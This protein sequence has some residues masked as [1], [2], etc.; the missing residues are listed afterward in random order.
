VVEARASGTL[1]AVALLDLDHFK[2]INDTLG[3]GAG[4]ALLKSASARIEHAVK[5]SDVVGRLGGDEFV[6]LVRSVG[7]ASDAV[8]CVERVLA[9][10]RDPF[11]VE[12]NTLYATASAG[13]SVMSDDASAIEGGAPLLLREADIALYEAKAAGR[14]CWAIFSEGLRAEVTARVAIG[15][16]LRTALARDELMMWYQPDVDLTT[17]KVRAVEALVRWNHPDGHVRGAGTFI[18]VAE[19]SGLILEIGEWVIRQSFLE[20]ATIVAM[21]PDDPVT[22]RVNLAAAQFSGDL[23]HQIDAALAASGVPPELICL[24]IT[25]SALVRDLAFVRETLETLRTRGLRF[26][27][28]DFGAGYAS[29]T[30]LRDF[31]VELIKID[32]SF[33]MATE[34]DDRTWRLVRAI[35]T[36]ADQL[37]IAVTAEGVETREQA[38][39]LRRIGCP[40]AQGYLFAPAVPIPTLRPLIENGFGPQTP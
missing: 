33:L 10:L 3:H 21:R 29:L 38:A 28:D 23:V 37:G 26:A 36:L 11:V 39:F 40:T 16:E 15:S 8:Q 22:V 14:D 19:S 4:D 9:T 18:G 25:E 2:D 13:I 6:V 31:P 24:E 20:A 5:Q 7:V 17:G 34:D 35:V 1:V 30:Y 32:R 12:G 27:I